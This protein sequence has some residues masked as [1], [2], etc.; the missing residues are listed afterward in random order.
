MNEML[1]TR[2]ALQLMN[3]N[4]CKHN[5]GLRA[6]VEKQIGIFGFSQD[7]PQTQLSFG[8]LNIFFGRFRLSE[9][10]FFI[11][12]LFKQII[13]VYAVEHKTSHNFLKKLFYL[14][15]T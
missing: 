10:I 8:F 5:F 12:K 6:R 3:G 11:Q 13:L 4:F 1:R 15:A 7:H 2:F 14:N 9:C